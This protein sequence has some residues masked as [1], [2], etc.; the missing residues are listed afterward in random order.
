MSERVLLKREFYGDFRRPYRV[1]SAKEDDCMIGYF[2]DE[3]DFD[4]RVEIKDPWKQ[5]DRKRLGFTK[6]TKPLLLR[7]EDLAEMMGTDK[8]IRLTVEIIE[9]D[10]E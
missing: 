5:A 3:R 8:L 9:E 10:E 2:H 7:H 4:V 6:K 1:N